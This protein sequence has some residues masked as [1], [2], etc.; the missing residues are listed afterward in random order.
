MNQASK[1]NREAATHDLATQEMP[2]EQIPNEQ[3]AISGELGL[4]A[5]GLALLAASGYMFL[6]KVSKT[7]ARSSN[8]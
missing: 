2:K 5:L 7:L 6:L 4:I 3:L 1:T 8:K